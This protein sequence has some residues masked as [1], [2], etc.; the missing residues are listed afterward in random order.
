LRGLARCPG[1]GPSSWHR[2]ASPSAA[3]GSAAATGPLPPR[4]GDRRARGR[5]PPRGPLPRAG[6][7]RR[8]SAAARA[9]RRS[10]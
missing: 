5:R 1:P 10:S 7:P 9:P 8:P 4:P 6:G 3:H 2:S